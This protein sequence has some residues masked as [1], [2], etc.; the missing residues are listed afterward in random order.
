MGA[1]LRPRPC[2]LLRYTHPIKTHSP[3]DQPFLRG[4]RQNDVMNKHTRI[5]LIMTAL[6]GALAVTACNTTEGVGKDVKAA[7]RSL[8]DAAHDANH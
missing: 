4:C 1:G 5:V 7:G 8:E 3:A 6:I 2:H